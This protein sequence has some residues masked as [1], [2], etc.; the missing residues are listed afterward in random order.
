M[1]DNMH[2]CE[3]AIICIV[4]MNKMDLLSNFIDELESE[5]TNNPFVPII[6]ECWKYSKDPIN[7]DISKLHPDARL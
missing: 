5:N 6:I 7:Q 2:D 4:A 3:Y 1:L